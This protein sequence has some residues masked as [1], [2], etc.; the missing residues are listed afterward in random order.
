MRTERLLWLAIGTAFGATLACASGITF[1]CASNI[2]ATEAGTCNYL[3]SVVAGY[4][5]TTFSNANADIYIQMG[6]TGLGESTTGYYNFVPY[7]TYLTDLT[8]EGGGGTVRADAIASL[9]LTEPSLYNG[10]DIE[11]TSALGN[12]L[13]IGGM[14]GTTAG[15][16]KCFT[17]GSGSCY[18]GIVTIT[19]PA[20]LASETG[21]TQGL[22]WDQ[23]GGTIP[24]NDYDFY[25][26]V[27]H[28]TDEVLGT[29]SC[30]GTSG[31]LV[32]DCGGS[33][34]SAVDL[35]R[36]DS[37]GSRVFIDT[38]AGA[39]FAYNGVNGTGATNGV[40]T[41]AVYNT[42]ANGNDYAD[43][44]ASCL[45]VQDGT[46][47]LGKAL[48]I[49]TDGGGEINILDAVGYNVITPEPGTLALFGAGFAV[50]TLYRRRHST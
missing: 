42:V 49:T 5:D 39:Y 24:G 3:N 4:Y 17:P 48:N 23:N 13:G 38:T 2:D 37:S 1:T 47:C 22:Y 15:G 29:S 19:T 36:Y 30:V 14:V 18:N 20:N 6:T 12:A 40:P 25:S 45:D 41:G 16:G 32:D 43:F 44:T 10:A 27:E 21:G 34:P 46:G 50:L 28:E 9:P 26:V 8:N 31:S 11:V 7:S 33:S 35:F